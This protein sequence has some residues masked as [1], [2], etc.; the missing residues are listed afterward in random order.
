MN[1]LTNDSISMW[2][3]TMKR[4]AVLSDTSYYHHY[5]RSISFRKNFECDQYAKTIW[6]IDI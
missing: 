1:Y 5:F 6:G 2:D 4:L 3:I